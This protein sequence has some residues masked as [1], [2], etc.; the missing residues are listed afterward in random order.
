MQL[1]RL[2]RNK[3]VTETKLEILNSDTHTHTHMPI[4][5]GPFFEIVCGLVILV[6]V[7][8]LIHFILVVAMALVQHFLKC[9][10]HQLLTDFGEMGRGIPWSDKFGK[11]T[12]LSEIKLVSLEILFRVFNMLTC[13]VTLPGDICYI[14]LTFWISISSVSFLQATSGL[15]HILGNVTLE[16]LLFHS[17]SGES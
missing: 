9:E 1:E 15:K 14:S 16:A 8:I 12:E 2:K 10:F 11:L 5:A 6:G 17:V 3:T 13:A 4:L 7:G